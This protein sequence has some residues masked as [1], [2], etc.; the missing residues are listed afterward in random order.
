MRV[1]QFFYNFNDSFTQNLYIHSK[2]LALFVQKRVY[3]HQLKTKK[4]KNSQ[5]Y[6]IH[7]CMVIEMSLSTF[8]KNFEIFFLIFLL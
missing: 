4:T 5:F 7:V 2:Q 3:I 6:T 1:E 8:L